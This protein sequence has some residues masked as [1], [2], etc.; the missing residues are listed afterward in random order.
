MLKYKTVSVNGGA[1]LIHLHP[2]FTSLVYR[3]PAPRV[4]YMLLTRRHPSVAQSTITIL[5][6]RV[7]YRGRLYEIILPI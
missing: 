5:R 1:I 2:R 6:T 7:S 4:A 3:H